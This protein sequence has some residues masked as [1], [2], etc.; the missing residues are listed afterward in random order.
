MLHAPGIDGADEQAGEEDESLRVLD[1]AELGVVDLEEGVAPGEGHVGEQH[2]HQ[3]IA[4]Q[5][6]NQLDPS[7][8]FP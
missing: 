2:R 8:A 3:E 5:P 1:E 7:H 4:A 6:V